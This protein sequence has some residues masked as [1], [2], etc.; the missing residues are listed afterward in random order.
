MVMDCGLLDAPLL[1]AMEHRSELVAGEHQIA[2]RKGFCS[3]GHECN[4][5]AQGQRGFDLDPSHHDLEIGAGKVEPMDVGRLGDG[6]PP[7][8]GFDGLPL[9]P[10]GRKS[11][12]GRK[13]HGKGAKSSSD[14]GEPP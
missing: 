12:C 7:H 9:G 1:E 14:H 11:G 10:L 4:P 5:A 13:A 8:R 3:V 2:H 6:G